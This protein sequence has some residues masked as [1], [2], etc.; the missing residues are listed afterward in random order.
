MGVAVNSESVNLI[1]GLEGVLWRC[2][3]ESINFA[4]WHQGFEETC[5]WGV[6]KV[7]SP[8]RVNLIQGLEGV[9]SV[10]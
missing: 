9:L 8:S 5:I 7:K 4:L 6:A 3:A 10:A 2:Y 1:Q